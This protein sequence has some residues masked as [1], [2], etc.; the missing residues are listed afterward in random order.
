MLKNKHSKIIPPLPQRNIYPRYFIIITHTIHA[1]CFKHVETQH[2]VVEQKN[3][4][5]GLNK[6]H[7]SHVCCQVEHLVAALG[8]LNTVLNATQVGLS[9]LIT[10]LILYTDTHMCI[11]KY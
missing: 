10:E 9:K 11:Y 8:H 2:G 1:R 3:G 4:L 7:A 6:A 5:V